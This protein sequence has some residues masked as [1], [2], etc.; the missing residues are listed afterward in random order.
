MS[1][2]K[3]EIK[4]FHYLFLTFCL[5][6]VLC[7]S[8]SKVCLAAEP[9]SIQDDVGLDANML[10]YMLQ[11]EQQ[12]KPKT[13]KAL[14]EIWDPNRYISIDEVQPGMEAYCLTCYKDTNIEKFELEVLSVVRNIELGR[15]AILVQGIDERFIHTGPVGGCS[16]SPV[17]IDG[18]LA[19]ALA[20]AWYFSKDPLYGVTPIEEMLKVGRGG[21]SEQNT[22]QAGFVFDFSRPIDLAEIDRQI[23]RPRVSTSNKL[24][25]ASPLPCPLITSGLPAEAC[26]QLEAF[27]EPFGLM[28]I[29]GISVG[30]WQ[31]A[32]GQDVSLEPGAVLIVPLVSGDIT[33]FVLGTATEVIGD[34][35]YGFGH[36][37]LSRGPV[38]LPMATGQVHTVISSLARS[39]KVG[40]TLEI[41]GALT[42]DESAAILGRIGKKPKMIPMTIRVDRYN[43]PEKRVYNCQVANDRLLT[44]ILFAS[45]VSGAAS[46][47]GD[48]PLDHTIE[49]KVAINVQ[50]AEPITF[51]NVSTGSGVNDMILESRASVALLMNNPFKKINIESLDFE[52][53]I[54]PKNIISQIWS[55][56]LSD[57]KVKA[58]ETIE[59][60]AVV[61]SFL[62]GKKKYQFSLKIPEDMPPGGYEL[63]VCGSQD[64]AQF[65]RKAVPYKF[66]AQSL[67]SLIEAI[68][69]ALQIRQDKLYCL[70]ALPPGG[71]ALERA[72][73]PDLPATKALVLQNEKRILRAQ[74]YQH[75]LEE[76]IETGTIIADRKVAHI[77]V[78]K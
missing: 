38:D 60:A 49:Y 54:M 10:S 53:Q 57:T 69:N 42:T 25:G 27:V 32:T 61:E 34:N 22:T 63:T 1:E 64:Y 29:P 13:P 14:T 24:V 41:V 16:G 23:T 62:A 3:V 68:N 12:D 77:M 26:K 51:E 28:V 36:S 40:S 2:K 56:N 30:G 75:W 31:K 20:F 5:F 74:P 15:D 17:Y 37:F 58:G 76:S 8:I 4:T 33:I 11:S 50:Q 21:S 48:F 18:R 72:E 67:P 6:V 35:V 43:D 66:I 9:N 45:A 71:V 70:L 39:F 78:E 55:V 52:I 44:P 73:L 7:L 65:L 46:Y 19:G 47:L 59:I